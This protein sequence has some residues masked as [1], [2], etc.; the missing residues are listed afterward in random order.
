MQ[1]QFLKKLVHDS[2]EFEGVRILLPDAQALPPH[3][4]LTEIGKVSK[5]FVDCGGT[6]RQR[7]N[8]VLQTWVADD[9]DH[10]LLRDK[11]IAILG[12]ATDLGLTGEEE[13]EFEVQQQTL[14]MFALQAGEIVDGVLELRL[15]TTQTQCLAPDRCGVPGVSSLQVLGDDCSGPGCC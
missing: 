12:K 7:T 6:R 15:S 8:C 5:D 13:I 10:R 4:H 14:S 9:K 2:S 11:L 1:L 3:F